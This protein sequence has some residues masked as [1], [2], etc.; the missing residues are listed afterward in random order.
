M[1]MVCCARRLN[2]ARKVCMV[3]AGKFTP[4]Q[5]FSVN[6]GAHAGEQAQGSVKAPAAGQ[7][8]CREAGAQQVHTC[9]YCL[10][11]SSAASAGHCL[12]QLRRHIWVQHMLQV[13]ASLQEWRA[14]CVRCRL[15]SSVKL[16]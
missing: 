11:R 14:D 2:T 12:T 3:C 4:A 1:L 15:C 6:R 8:T 13:L 10:Q 5:L 9:L 7:L 16:S